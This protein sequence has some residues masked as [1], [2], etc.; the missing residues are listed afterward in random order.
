MIAALAGKL[1]HGALQLFC[2]SS[3]DS[4][5]WYNR[6]VHPRQRVRRHLQYEDYILGDVVPLC[7]ENQ[8]PL[9]DTSKSMRDARQRW[10][11]YFER[12]YVAELLTQTSGNVSAAA[13]LAGVD[14][15]YMHRMIT[16]CGLREVLAKTR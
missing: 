14:R 16:R 3:V 8:P 7:E 10:L 4:E 13:V 15:V 11:R 9:I 5:S 12:A 6:H 1:E 2:V